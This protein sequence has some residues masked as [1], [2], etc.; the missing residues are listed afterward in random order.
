M[1]QDV[2][3]A[4][5][6]QEL[7]SHEQ[8]RELQR[9]MGGYRVSQGIYV[10]ARLGIADLLKDGPLSSDALAEATGMCGPALYRLLRF[11]TGAGLFR[12]VAPGHF[13]LTPLGAGLRTDVPE[14]LA[15]TVLMLLDDAHWSA[16]GQLR[17]SVQTGKTAFGHVHEMEFFDYIGQHPASVAVFHRAMTS[18]TARSGAAI[19]QA[20][21]FA[22]IRRL[23]DV[24]GGHGL[25]LATILQAHPA[26]R[27]VLFDRPE[28][29][30]GATTTLEAA[31]V[32][33]RC[34]IVGGDFFATVPPGGDAYLLRQIIHDWDDAQAAA[35]L[36]HCRRAM[37]ASGRLLVIERAVAP[38]HSQG[39]G[40]LHLDMEMLVNLGGVQRT[41]AEYGTL[42]EAADLELC[43]I[44]PL[45][46][47]DQFSVYV[48]IAT[49][50]AEGDLSV[51]RG[52]R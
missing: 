6:A 21:D 14:S 4:P 46:D 1:V 9:L 27:G 30:Q 28:V 11:L 31:G 23:V 29:I 47:A 44:V 22:G 45:G 34:E 7:P 33:D 41:D 13:A 20:Y 51:A 17:Y 49:T 2:G 10:V 35:I 36:T 3:T 42:F 52:H 40:V 39:P 26:M 18:S 5:S 32:A 24:G 19:T 50:V 48:G 12:E 16:W 8:L 43:A 15:H 38:D 25:F 37:R